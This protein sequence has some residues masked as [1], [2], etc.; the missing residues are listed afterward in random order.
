MSDSITY[1]YAFP[2]SLVRA[3]GLNELFLAK[4]SEVQKK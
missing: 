2:S 3:D 1:Q 4:Y